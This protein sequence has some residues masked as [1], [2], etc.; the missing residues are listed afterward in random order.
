MI[1]KKIVPGGHM[2][3]IKDSAGL[4]KSAASEWSEDKAPRLGAAL[5]YYTIFSIAPMLV[6]A[7]GIAGL[8]FGS[9]AAQGEVAKALQ[10]TLGSQG[11]QAIQTMIANANKPSQGIIA[12]VVGIVI[13]L[14]GASGVF[15]QLKD[16]MNTIWEVPEQKRG[17]K[18]AVKN[19]VTAFGMVLSVGFLLLVSLVVDTVLQALGDRVSASIPG[20]GVLLQIV[21]LVVSFGVVTFLF[22]ILFKEIPDANVKWG[23][24]WVGALFTALLFTIG[25]FLLG[26]YLARGAVSSSFGAAGSLVV[27]LVWIYY[28][29]QIMFFGAEFTQVYAN[30]FGSHIKPASGNAGGPG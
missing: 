4:L 17:I 25:R 19:K 20:G 16:A 14:I 15:G 7:I 29:A 23:D 13:L 27:V 3:K 5:A 6:I 2:M 12:T 24:V 22:A 11:A 1:R 21:S 9:A 28:S 18:G 10:G 8:V 26:I 30:R